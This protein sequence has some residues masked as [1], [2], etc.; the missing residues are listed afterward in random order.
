[1]RIF[2][3]YHTPD[4]EKARAIDAALTL[5]RPGT[6]CYLAPRN[7]TGGA[8]WLPGLANEIARSDAVLFVAGTRIGPWQE[9]EYYEALRLSREQ[10]G[11]PRLVPV[12]MAGQAPGLPFFA[13]LHQIFAPEPTAADSLA[14]IER[15][16]DDAGMPDT[17]RPWSRFQPYKGLPALQEADAAFFFGRDAEAAEILNLIAQR[18][19]RIIALVG[20]S[21]V[22]KSS[23]ARAGVLA[24]L[25]S[26]AWPLAT[27]KWPAGLKD[28]RAFLPLVRLREGQRA[29][30]DVGPDDVG[31]VTWVEPSPPKLGKYCI[32]A[33]FPNRELEAF[34]TDFMLAG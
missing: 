18:P 21:G 12:V 31:E 10:S 2:I 6:E 27:G 22:G 20:Q 32:R 34:Y 25:R 28:S 14:A 11:R 23:L 29:V 8:Y 1:M 7:N 17:T 24:A 5:R 15:G 19:D 33:K 30:D 26:Q 4:L 9:L 16:L 13:Q 3:S